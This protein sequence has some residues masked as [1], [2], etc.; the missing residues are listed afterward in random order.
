MGGFGG[1]AGGGRDESGR[2][3]AGVRSAPSECGEPVGGW[4]SGDGG[5]GCGGS[6]ALRE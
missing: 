3:D 2:G 5:A 4:V 6:G 1:G